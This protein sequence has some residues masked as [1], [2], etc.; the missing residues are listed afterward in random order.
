M[1]NNNVII[2][3]AQ[4]MDV[5]GISS[6]ENI[7]FSHPWTRGM[8]YNDICENEITEYLVAK[9]GDMYIGYAG[10]WIVVDEAHVTNVCT[11][12]DYRR[13][14]IAT[15]LIKKLM[16]IAVAKKVNSMTL[17]VRVSNVSAMKLYEKMG[18][19]IYGKRK[20]YYSDNGEDA[21]VLWNETISDFV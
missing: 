6:L 17:E 5:D 15:Q 18:F 11:H 10:M 7:C 9:T 3:K 16:E 21:Y 1:Q 20:N 2:E 4:E 19:H 8:L 12:P 14:G 13:S